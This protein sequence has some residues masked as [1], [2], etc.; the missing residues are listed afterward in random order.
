MGL[1]NPLHI[2]VLALIVLLVFGARR[3]PELGRSLGSGIKE[4]KGSLEAGHD[5]PEP[6]AAGERP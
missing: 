3:L 1:S 2:A 6:P 4:F 5:A